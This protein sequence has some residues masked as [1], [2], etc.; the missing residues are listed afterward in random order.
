MEQADSVINV[1]NRLPE[2]KTREG[3][4]GI[5]RFLQN[6]ELPATA[7][8]A[9]KKRRY[10]QRFGDGSGFHIRDGN[11]FNGEREVIVPVIAARTH[12]VQRIYNDEKKGL[13]VGE[14]AFFHQVSES[15][16]NI[17]KKFTDGFLNR[18]GDVKVATVPR[19]TPMSIITHRPNE[20]WG[21]DLINMRMYP[22]NRNG[23]KEYIMTVVDYF[24][25]K[26]WA[27]GIANRS[28]GLREDIQRQNDAERD[29]RDNPEA[30]AAAP[31]P[32]PPP[33]PPENNEE[34][35]APP[36]QGR[37]PRQRRNRFENDPTY[38]AE[39]QRVRDI[40][41]VRRRPKKGGS[42][43][44]FNEGVE[45]L[46]GGVREHGRARTQNTPAAKIRFVRRKTALFKSQPENANKSDA[47][48]AALVDAEWRIRVSPALQRQRVRERR[49][50]GRVA[51]QANAP[52]VR[53]Q[54][55]RN[56]PNTLIRAFREI[57][58]EAGA[59]PSIIQVD[60]EFNVGGFK[61][62]CDRRFRDAHTLKIVAVLSHQSF[63]NGKVERTNREI[64]KKTKAGFIRHNNLVWY[65]NRGERL[66]TYVDNINN[67][68]AARS[69]L[70][71]NELWYPANVAD[72]SEKVRGN[73]EQQRKFMDERSHIKKMHRQFVVGQEVR[74]NLLQILP[75]MRAKRKSNFGWNQIA[76]HFSPE[77][78][79][80]KSAHYY[81]EDSAKQDEYTLKIEN[82]QGNEEVV[83][84]LKRP[85]KFRAC[86]L[87]AVHNRSVQTH[88][89]PQTFARAQYM[90]RIDN[91]NRI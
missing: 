62:F 44:T 21:C 89:E 91:P 28:N 26:V 16:L 1:L 9:W 31:E 53:E 59:E 36:D 54:R 79:T 68:R 77:I 12:A 14:H 30:E 38:V 11:L 4:Q 27:R 64:R 81:P 88:L 52:A 83:K 34:L 75:K 51:Q 84:A 40:S 19:R 78:Y 25:G 23:G 10:K 90:N 39:R 70:S 32:V 46:T 22:S 61:D 69:K 35:P 74:L 50:Q 55:L 60:N 33:P 43:E 5:I 85:R 8:T 63:T 18:Q 15:Y 49:E 45:M 57:I 71:P 29:A 80:I 87:I 65:G 37:Q 20:R 86:D 76:V 66:Q 13:G 47:E 7:N 6:G 2:F 73:Q 3:I 24:S 56:T 58:E 67:Q 48:I 17:P 82:E 42:V 41:E 72:A